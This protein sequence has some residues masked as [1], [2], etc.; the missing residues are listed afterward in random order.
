MTGQDDPPESLRRFQETGDPESLLECVG[1][2]GRDTGR[3][4][5]ALRLLAPLFDALGHGEYPPVD[6]L[7]RHRLLEYEPEMRFIVESMAGSGKADLA[8]AAAKLRQLLDGMR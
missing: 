6:D 7:D 2:M 1:L 8:A 5:A 3:Y 4:T